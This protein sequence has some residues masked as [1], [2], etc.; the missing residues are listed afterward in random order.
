MVEL[1]YKRVMENI[2]PQWF[3]NPLYSLKSYFKIRNNVKEI[4]KKLKEIL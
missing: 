1:K 2:K 4:D 3:K